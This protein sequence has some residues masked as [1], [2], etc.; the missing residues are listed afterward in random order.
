MPFAVIDFETTGF[1]PERTDRVIEVGIVLADDRGRIEHEWT[2]L[3]NPHRGVGASHVHRITAA[4]VADA[5]DFADVGDHIL[6]LLGGRAV[7][8]HNASFDMRFLHSELGRADYAVAGRPVALCSMK[9]SRRV[10]GAAKLAE[11]CDAVG[12][13]LDGAHSALGDAR[14]TAGLLP[15]LMNGCGADREWLA[16]ARRS[17]GYAWP[18]RSGHTPSIAVLPRATPPARAGRR[19]RG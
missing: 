9:W 18:A 15:Y 19:R 6:D 8:A 2:T 17:V 13:A 4:D 5:P 3:V 11:C 7:V 1:V 12:I 16:E 14:A 10:I